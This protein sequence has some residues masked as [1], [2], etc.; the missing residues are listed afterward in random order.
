MFNLLFKS[1]WQALLKNKQGQA[2]SRRRREGP[3]TMR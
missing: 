2:E 3:E 1:A